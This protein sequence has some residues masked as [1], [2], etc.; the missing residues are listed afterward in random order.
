MSPAGK[1]EPT[2]LQTASLPRQWSLLVAGSLLLAAIFAMARLPAALL[3]GPMLA[4]I[5]LSSNGGRIGVPRRAVYASQTIVGCLIARSITGDIVHAFLKDWPLLLG[6]VLVIILSSGLLGWLIS[7]WRVLPGSTAVWG[8]APGGA[9]VMMIMAGAFGADARLVA[10]MQYLRVVLVAAVATLVARIWVGEGTSASL[11]SSW[12]SSFAS[13]SWGGFATISWGGF[14]T[15]LLI[16]AGGGLLGMMLRIPAGALLA[17]MALAAVLEAMGLVSLVLPQWLLA[18]TYAVLGWSIG[19]SFNREILRHAARAL[20][21]IT[22]TI[23]VMIAVCAALA[24]VLV[25]VAGID[26]L[27]A[28]LATSP[29][30]MDSVAIIGAASKVDLS[31]V[32][33]LQVVRLV[34]VLMAGPPLARFLAQ[35]L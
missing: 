21:P 20:L 7:R 35:R 32:M 31:F 14:A 29:G 15:T 17:P 25:R 24:A 5:V 16:A 4:G 10:F 3:L 28:Y 1:S 26:P 19:L 8:S 9:S 23:G 13:I 11:E 22:L 34:I 27:T 33:A 2:L 18:I 6:T 30:G 12:W